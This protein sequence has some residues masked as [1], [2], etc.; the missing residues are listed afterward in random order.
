VVV[1]HRPPRPQKRPWRALSPDR[2]LACKG[3]C[4]PVPSASAPDASP[5][6]SPT[7]SMDAAQDNGSLNTDR[8]LINDASE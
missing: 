3:I 8:R 4:L 7:P 1:L 2:P 5:Q 6:S